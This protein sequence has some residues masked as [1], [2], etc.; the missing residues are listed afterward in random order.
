[1]VKYKEIGLILTGVWFDK[2]LAQS[3]N[4]SSI[5]FYLY[6]TKSGQLPQVTLYSEVKTIQ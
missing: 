2:S 5:Q 1:M 6:G 3:D 4:F